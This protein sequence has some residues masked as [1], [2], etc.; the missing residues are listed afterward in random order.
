M[1]I[2]Y[3][4][5]MGTGFQARIKLIY[6]LD[7]SADNTQA[8][9][10]GTFY[11]ETGASVS[12]SVNSWGRTGDLANASGSN[13]NINT[14]SGGGLETITSF[15]AFN[16]Y[17]DASVRCYVD[18]INAVGSV[19]IEE[20]FTLDA[21]ALA[22]YFTDDTYA[23][24]SIT[25]TGFSVTG[26][27]ATGN[28]GTLNNVQVQ[29]NVGTASA[30]GASTYTK[31][32]YGT[33]A[34]TG[35]IPDTLYWFRVRVSNSTYGYGAWGP[36]HSVRTGATVPTAPSSAFYVSNIGQSTADA[37]GITVADDG[38]S[39]ID[40]IVVRVS[41]DPAFG[42]YTDF[43]AATAGVTVALTG[44]T[45]G[46]L[47]YV[48]VF[49]HNAVGYSAASIDKSFTTLPGV[50]ININGIWKNA[51]PYVNVSGVWKPATHYVKVSGVWQQ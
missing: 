48:R 14:P 18:G 43:Y 28:G 33:P 39:A 46:T 32:S 24:S 17:G 1:P 8:I 45:P 3:G 9:F 22:P 26:Y 6:A 2:L 41:T 20:T 10:N 42:T 44:L 34:V 51:V 31:G 30:T 23:A 13:L 19:R 12:D 36:W 4:P 47:Y 37:L 25:A 40:L 29:Y 38:G 35:L 11:L 49:A 50:S 5:W 27:T 7:H 15:P 21:G 16:K